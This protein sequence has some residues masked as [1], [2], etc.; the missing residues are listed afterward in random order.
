MGI[1][2]DILTPGSSEQVIPFVKGVIYAMISVCATCGYMDIGRIHMVVLSILSVGLLLS[3]NYFEMVVSR[4][5]E[6]S[7][8]NGAVADKGK[9]DEGKKDE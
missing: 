8:D 2:G 5:N 1:L 7:D 6:S 9:S 4:L 3:I